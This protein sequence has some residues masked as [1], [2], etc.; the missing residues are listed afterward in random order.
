MRF[1]RDAPGVAGKVADGSVGTFD[2]I[3]AF[4]QAQVLWLAFRS[5]HMGFK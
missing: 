4:E 3:N 5:L 1:A 2:E